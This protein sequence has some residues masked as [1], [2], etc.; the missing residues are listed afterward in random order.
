MWCTWNCSDYRQKAYLQCAFAYVVL[1]RWHECRKRHTDHTENAS[2]LNEWACGSWG[3]ILANKNRCTGC[4]WNAFE[5]LF[6]MS[7]FFI[8][9]TQFSQRD[10]KNQW[11]IV[12]VVSSF[13]YMSI[14]QNKG[15]L[16]HD[17]S[18]KIASR[19]TKT[20]QKQSIFYFHILRCLSLQIVHVHLSPYLFFYLLFFAGCFFITCLLRLQDWVHL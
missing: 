7:W 9:F 12:T 1:E 8:R 14:S 6:S 10:V 18:R 5:R 17:E 15:V 2:R 16:W 20:L 3:W 13:W 19:I 4:T 11:L